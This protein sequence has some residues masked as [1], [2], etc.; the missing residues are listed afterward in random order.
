MRAGYANLRRGKKS[1][2]R[3][4]GREEEG[5]S[6]NRQELAA[7]VFALR[8]TPV[9]NPK[10]YLCDNQALLNAVKKWVGEDRKATSV[11]APDADM[12]Q[13]PIEEL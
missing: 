7:F 10:L 8:C 6:S 12:L 9:T 13:E 5:S 11:R 2:Q 4:V 3:K 1:Q